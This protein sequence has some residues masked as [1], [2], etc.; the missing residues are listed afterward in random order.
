MQAQSA[1]L[2]AAASWVEVPKLNRSSWC[3]ER[4]AAGGRVIEPG[5]ATGANLNARDDRMC[6]TPATLKS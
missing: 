4:C 5:V 6:F 3:V 1:G 2:A